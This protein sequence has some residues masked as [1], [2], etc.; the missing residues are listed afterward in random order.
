MKSRRVGWPR[1]S[2]RL[3]RVQTQFLDKW[4]ARRAPKLGCPAG[5]PS[6]SE[7]LRYSRSKR[8]RRFASQYLFLGRQQ[9]SD[10]LRTTPN[11]P[12]SPR[13][14]EQLITA[15]RSDSHCPENT[16]RFT[17]LLSRQSRV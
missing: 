3:L 1:P 11:W 2:P 5:A 16:A 8:G 10:H 14:P 4:A 17:S 9:R 12:C 7:G 6:S 15:N 13:I